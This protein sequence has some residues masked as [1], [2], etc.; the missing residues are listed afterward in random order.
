MSEQ[1]ED[2]CAWSERVDGPKHS[3][4]F[5]GDNPYIICVYCD[6]MRDAIN[7]RVIREGKQGGPGDKFMT[8]PV[9]RIAAVLREHRMVPGSHERQGGAECH[10]GAAWDR[11]NDRCS[12]VEVA[13]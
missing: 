5:D 9:D 13:Q 7:G 2:F 10:C 12:T 8:S 3:W 1:D 6:E 11:W 4:V